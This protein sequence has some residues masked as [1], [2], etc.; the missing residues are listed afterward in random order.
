MTKPPLASGVINQE[1]KHGKPPYICIS[2]QIVSS[3]QALA[4]A[5]YWFWV[6]WYTYK[7]GELTW[8][9]E[10]GHC[11]LNYLLGQDNFKTPI[12]KPF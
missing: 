7:P 4:G 2:I 1:E 8:M 3:L 6:Q 9:D 5:K 11:L 10:N 12:T